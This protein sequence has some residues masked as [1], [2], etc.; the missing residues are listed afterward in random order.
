[1]DYFYK[2][3]EIPQP[4]FFLIACNVLVINFLKNKL[5]NQLNPSDS[6][7]KFVSPFLVSKYIFIK[8]SSNDI[9]KIY[10]LFDLYNLLNF[11]D[12]VFSKSLFIS[13]SICFI[14]LH[15]MIH[16][17]ICLSNIHKIPYYQLI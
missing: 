2:C 8:L 4:F 13:F 6:F 15:L 1:M 12:M 7:S 10:S 5:K 11:F 9:L 3:A 16:F 14:K 17:Y